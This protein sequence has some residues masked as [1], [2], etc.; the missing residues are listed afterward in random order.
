MLLEL[1]IANFAIIE[2]LHLILGL[3]LTVVT[4]ETGSGKS[5]IVD[6]LGALVGER[7][8]TTTVRAGAER[9]SLEGICSLNS[10]PKETVGEICSLLGE[11]GIDINDDTLILAREIS[12]QGRSLCRINGRAVTQGLLQAVGQRLVDIHGQSEH[13]SLLRPAEHVDFLD[14]YA[15][16]LARRHGLAAQVAALRQMRQELGRLRLDEEERSRRADLL[17]FQVQEI[18]SARLQPGEDESLLAERRR[19]ENAE[20]L[21]RFS[22]QA[23]T[24]LSEGIDGRASLLDLLAEAMSNLRGLA[25]L[26]PSLQ[27]KVEA[28][29]GASIQ[30]E[31]VARELRAYRDQVQFDPRRLGEVQERLELIQNLKRKCGGTIEEILAFGARAARELEALSHHQER[32]EELTQQEEALK[33]EVGAQAW[34]LSQ[35][36]REA[37]ESLSQAMENEMAQLS[38]PKVRF[39][40][41]MNLREDPDG[42]PTPGA[43]EAAAPCYA[44]DAKGI[45]QV[46]FLISVNPGEPLRPLARVASGGETSRLMLAMKSVLAQ[47]DVVPTLVFDEIDLGLGGRSGV[48]VGQKLAQLSQSHQVVC[49][50]HL[51]QLAAFADVHF[52][53][54][55]YLRQDR[56]LVGVERLTP[57]GQLEELALMLG[58]ISPATKAS[59]LEMVK[60][61]KTWKRGRIEASREGDVQLTLEDTSHAAID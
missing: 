46:E 38:M 45:D 61:A 39:A 5:I 32:L 31:D 13:L 36:R 35:G 29:E 26:D 15:G 24:I 54:A 55:K 25:S 12:A 56:T 34:A 20:T 4:G 14:R 2:R 40:V 57:Q 19:L 42:V 28:V 44:F 8:D 18:S 49:I 30:L 58:G 51:P 41:S 10:L 52:S 3:G 53:V 47:A 22:H 23:Y 27:G 7:A 17:R 21:A 11:Y 1:N 59:A 6:A 16:L 9:A 48:V 33:R 50:T 43:L 37:A 60:R